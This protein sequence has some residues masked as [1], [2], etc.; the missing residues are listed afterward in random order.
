MLFLVLGLGAGLIENVRWIQARKVAG[1]TDLTTIFQAFLHGPEE[2]GM[3]MKSSTLVLWI[4]SRYVV[5]FSVSGA[6]YQGR[7]K[8]ILLTVHSKILNHNI[9]RIDIK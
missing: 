8:A 5:F 4:K 1:K 3:T 2:C 7:P 6:S 9:V